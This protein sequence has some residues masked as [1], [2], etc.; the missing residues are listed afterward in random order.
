MRKQ[1]STCATVSGQ[2]VLWN[3]HPINHYRIST[4]RSHW[5]Q[6]QETMPVQ[7]C[8]WAWKWIFNQRAMFQLFSVHASVKM[9][10]LAKI[11]TE[12]MTCIIYL[13]P[14]TE[15]PWRITNLVLCFSRSTGN[16]TFNLAWFLL[17]SK[18]NSRKSLCTFITS[19]YNPQVLYLGPFHPDVFTIFCYSSVFYQ[20]THRK[21]KIF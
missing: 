15:L 6:G 13:T 19:S 7:C 2:T 14:L 5:K 4:Q 17:S 10:S 11:W 21:H 8:V 3:T 12:M 20:W 18:L 1:T 16:W 9:A